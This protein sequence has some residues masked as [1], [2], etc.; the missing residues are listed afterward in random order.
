[1]SVKSSLFLLFLFLEG[2]VFGQTWQ[3]EKELLLKD[4]TYRWT[5]DEWGQ[6]Y[7]WKENT[8]WLQQNQNQAPFQETYK[9]LGEISEVQA[10]SGLRALVFSEGQQMMGI[11]DNTLQLKEDLLAFYNFNF[12]NISKVTISNRPDFIWLF[13]QYRERLILFNIIC[14]SMCFSTTT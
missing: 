1:M 9:I 11:I 8:I 13:D 4:S 5:S 6:L 7:Q 3:L 12:S 14:K 2:L 10:I